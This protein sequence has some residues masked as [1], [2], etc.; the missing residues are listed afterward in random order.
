MRMHRRI[1][2]GVYQ[3]VAAWC[4]RRFKSRVTSCSSKFTVFAMVLWHWYHSHGYMSKP[5]SES[6]DLRRPALSRKPVHVYNIRVIGSSCL[7]MPA[8]CIGVVRTMMKIV[9]T[10]HTVTV[11]LFSAR[12]PRRDCCMTGVH[13]HCKSHG[14]DTVTDTVDL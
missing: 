9:E 6:S 3:S 12:G 1:G 10:A 14:D 2:R 11:A 5:R 4:R 7:H 13:H 8:C